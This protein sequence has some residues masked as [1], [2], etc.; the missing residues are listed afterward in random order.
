MQ[1]SAIEGL[2]E[3]VTSLHFSVHHT[4]ILRNL[5]FFPS[6]PGRRQRYNRGPA[7]RDDRVR[8]VPHPLAPRRRQG[9]RSKG[10]AGHAQGGGLRTRANHHWHQQGRGEILNGKKPKC[11]EKRN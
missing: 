10:A 5:L 3:K 4:I 1:K 7:D 2:Y 9:L 6:L 11:A 8:D